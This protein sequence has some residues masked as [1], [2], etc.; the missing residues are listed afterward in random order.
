MY[1]PRGQRMYRGKG[2]SGWREIGGK[3]KYYRSLWEAN[4]ARY[5]EWL[6]E[7]DQ[8]QDWMFEPKTFYFEGIKR[9]CTNYKPDFWVLDKDDRQYWVEV[10]GWMDPKSITKIKR[11]NKYF[12]KEKLVV[13][14]KKWFNEFNP[15]MKILIHE[16]ET[17]HADQK[18]QISKNNFKK[19]FRTYAYGKVSPEASSSNSPVKCSKIPIKK[20]E[21][22][23]APSA[24]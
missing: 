13:V 7:H 14:D 6:K 19:R 3:K 4:Y 20:K 16:W 22:I 8:I 17:G 11:F 10:K 1:K 2:S 21:K 18:R 12:W 24:G 23:K 9:G 15:K 5:L